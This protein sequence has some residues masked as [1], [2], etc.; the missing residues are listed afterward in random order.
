MLSSIH[1]HIDTKMQLMITYQPKKVAKVKG[2]PR[3]PYYIIIGLFKKVALSKYYTQLEA[4]KF[5]VCQVGPQQLIDS[6]SWPP[7]IS[8]WTSTRP[9]SFLPSFLPS[10]FPSLLSVKMWLLTLPL[11]LP[12]VPLLNYSS[13]S[14][15]T[16][17][18]N[19]GAHILT[20]VLPP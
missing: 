8:P 9:P 10:F 7:A 14:S 11:T 2:Q 12:E 20:H 3:V 15:D 1:L 19:E 6:S 5:C 13:G 16:V 17:L 4:L 18:L